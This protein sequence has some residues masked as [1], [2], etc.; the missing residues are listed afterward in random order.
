MTQNLHRDFEVI[1]IYRSLD[2]M[3]LEVT[4]K[5][6][7]LIFLDWIICQVLDEIFREY[8]L[9]YFGRYPLW[10]VSVVYWKTREQL[11]RRRWKIYF[12]VRYF[13]LVKF[14]KLL[15]GT[16]CSCSVSG[17]LCF[18]IFCLK[19]SSTCRFLHGSGRSLVFIC[20]RFSYWLFEHV[21]F[22]FIFLQI[23][24]KYKPTIKVA[25]RSV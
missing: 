19:I 9:Y 1:Y 3:K 24:V 18:E 15:D 2:N 7:S 6:Q 4:L 25:R 11:W 14:L 21:L 23:C 5:F 8:R 13:F 22:L 16:L 20:I 17:F 10:A 12:S